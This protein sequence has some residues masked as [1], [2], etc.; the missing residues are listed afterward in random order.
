MNAPVNH[1]EMI[2]AL[3]DRFR[4]SPILESV[5]GQK[6]MTRGI[7]ALDQFTRHEILHDVQHFS[8]FTEDSDPYGEHDFGA[9]DHP[10]AGKVFWKMDYYADKSCQFG[11]EHP[12][13]PQ[14]CYRVLTIML[15]E[16]Y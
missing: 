11:S 6:L 13:D 5:L 14:R 4:S 16:E 12:H 1:T 15:A 3:N 10:K 9:V 7:A 2:A 8:D